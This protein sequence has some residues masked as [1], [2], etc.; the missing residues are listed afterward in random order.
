MI[1]TLDS[2]LDD[3][4][5]IQITRYEV[6]GGADQLDPSF[7]GSAIWS[8]TFERGKEAMMDV[9]A[10]PGQ[11][12]GQ[13]Q[14]EDL[15]IAGEDQIIGTTLFKQLQQAPFVHFLVAGIYGDEVVRNAMPLGKALQIRMV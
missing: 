7:M 3:W 9:D 13:R 6:S 8:R 15:H 2:L 4:P 10:T 1:D 11:L 5:C 14:R 12:L